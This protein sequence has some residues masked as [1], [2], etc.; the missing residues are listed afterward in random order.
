MTAHEEALVKKHNEILSMVSHDLK[1]PMVAII[2]AAQFIVND[3]KNK[4][5]DPVW[6]ELLNRVSNAGKGMQKLIEDIL[7]MAKLEAGNEVVETDWIPD[8][9]DE[10]KRAVRTFDFEADSKKIAM[11]VETSGV[12]PPVRWDMRRIHY[13]V[14]N[15]LLSNALKFTP[16]GGRVNISLSEADGKVDIRVSDTGRGIPP[17]E[18]KRIFNR[19][20]RGV[21]AS[22]RVQGGFG[23]GL[24]NANF[25][26]KKHGGCIKVESSNETGTTF[27]IKLPLDAA[28]AEPAGV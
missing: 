17:G 28:T 15:N 23:L 8:L 10:I 3:M 2:G 21:T 14:L 9:E 24:Y 18:Q 12:I 19:F 26:V 11:S 27:L 22:E 1:S 20:E 16:S 5:H 4:P 7:S 6:A 13:H 25:F